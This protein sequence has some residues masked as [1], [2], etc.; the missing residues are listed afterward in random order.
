MNTDSFLEPHKQVHRHTYTQAHMAMKSHRKETHK[1]WFSETEV[2]EHR[3]TNTNIHT[4]GCIQKDTCINLASY[5]WKDHQRDLQS[6]KEK[7]QNELH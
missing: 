4:F 5:T 3:D 6:N 1:H 2:L 7:S